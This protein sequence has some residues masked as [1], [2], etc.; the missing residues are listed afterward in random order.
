ME[1]NW[2]SCNTDRKNGLGESSWSIVSNHLHPKY[3][4]GLLLLTGAPSKASLVICIGD[5]RKA[6]P[7]LE[8]VHHC[9]GSSHVFVLHAKLHGTCRFQ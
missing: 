4:I 9:S 2:E 3:C 5:S 1:Q 8:R 6:P 7:E